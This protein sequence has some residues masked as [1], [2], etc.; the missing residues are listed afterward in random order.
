MSLDRLILHAH[1]K[2]RA[3]TWFDEKN[4]RM[5]KSEVR[6][7]DTTVGRA[8]FNDI[9]TP[10]MQFTNRVLEKGGVRDLIADLYEV[11]GQKDTT[12]VAD[13]IKDIGFTFA[14]RSGVTLA[15]SDISVPP[16]KAAILEGA[17]A[18][19]DLISARFP[20]WSDFRT[21]TD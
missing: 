10:E 18:E 7:I 11:S 6:I 19:V 5:D 15:V 8:I 16:E 4:N 2:V 3:E 20:P 17:V 13:R 1:I 12:D 14:T 9:L 21:G